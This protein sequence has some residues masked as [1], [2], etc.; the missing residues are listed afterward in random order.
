MLLSNAGS[1]SYVRGDQFTTT[2]L[3]GSSTGPEQLISMFPNSV[4]PIL[5]LSDHD[6]GR[7][8]GSE[9]SLRALPFQDVLPN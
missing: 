2:A 7:E 6:S 9:G 4:T 3:S 1:S 8:A 5:N